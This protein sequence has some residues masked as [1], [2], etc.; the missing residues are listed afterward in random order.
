MCDGTVAKVQLDFYLRHIIQAGVGGELRFSEKLLN[1]KKWELIKF[2]DE[3]DSFTFSFWTM[4]IM[5]CS[6]WRLTH[7]IFMH[8]TSCMYY[9]SSWV[10]YYLLHAHKYTYV[11]IAYWFVALRWEKIMMNISGSPAIRFGGH[12]CMRLV[13]NEIWKG[14]WT[15]A[16]NNSF[17]VSFHH[18]W[19]GQMVMWCSDYVC[20]PS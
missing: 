6:I 5:A 12:S 7:Q 4:V 8:S 9:I 19:E 14:K 17:A 18:F 16:G 11:Y 10:G 3:N 2:L 20:I 15:R 13:G 1:K